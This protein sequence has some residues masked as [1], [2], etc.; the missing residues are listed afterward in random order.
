MVTMKRTALLLAVVLAACAG[1]QAQGN[2]PA[3]GKVEDAIRKGKHDVAL[4][5][6]AKLLKK[7]PK[8]TTLLRARMSVLMAMQSNAEA[9]V[10]AQQLLK[11]LP[12]GLER[13]ALQTLEALLER[14]AE[15]LKGGEFQEVL[16]KAE[17]YCG[18]RNAMRLLEILTKLKKLLPDD[19]VLHLGLGEIYSSTGSF[20]RTKATAAFRK[21]LA[22]TTNAKLK[23]PSRQDPVGSR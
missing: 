15:V 5:L 18:A 6:L 21:F 20:N 11:A 2:G 1:V 19:P 23:N 14:K 8:D 17:L 10:C 9:L 4:S 3:E 13:T 7:S 12:A 22:L 16:E